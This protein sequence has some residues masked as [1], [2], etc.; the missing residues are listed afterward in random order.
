MQ[1]YKSHISENSIKNGRDQ[2]FAHPQILFPSVAICSC[3]GVRKCSK[4]HTLFRSGKYQVLLWFVYLVT[5][6]IFLVRV[7]CQLPSRDFC[8]LHVL[9]QGVSQAYD[10][11]HMELPPFAH[12]GICSHLL[13]LMVLMLVFWI[14][15]IVS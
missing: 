3:A 11:L 9:H 15:F 4:L 2:R 7:T 12:M 14:I 1:I 13:C 6:S 10:L 8:I 5:L